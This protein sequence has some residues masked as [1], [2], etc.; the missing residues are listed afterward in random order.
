MTDGFATM[1]RM[2]TTE[3]ALTFRDP[4][5]NSVSAIL[6]SPAERTDRAVLLCHG[7]LSNKN[8]TT[9]RTLTARL[10]EHDIAAFRFDFFG[11]GES[12]GPFERITLSLALGQALAALETLR[13]RGYGRI[14]LMGSSFGGLVAI[15]AASRAAADGP[16]LSTLGLKCPVPDFPEMLRLEFG[17]AG[18]ERWRQGHEIPDVTGGIKPVRL[19]YAFYE[20]CLAY[21]AYKAAEQIQAPVLIVQGDRD[22]YVPLSQSRRLYDALPGRKRLEVLPGAD[23]TFSKP[24]DFSRMIALLA[25]WLIAEMS[26]TRERGEARQEGFRRHTPEGIR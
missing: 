13:A 2:G 17:E 25:E 6:V 22:E 14:G 12:A 15:L 11:Q 21:D 24:A 10:L 23:H 5:G 16:V 26:E 7:F 1:A 20:D 9:N 19:R 18:M 4:A 8:S 3:Q